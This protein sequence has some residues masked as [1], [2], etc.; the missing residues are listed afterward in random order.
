MW[1]EVGKVDD[2][3]DA[4]VALTDLDLPA[5]LLTIRDRQWSLSEV[6]WVRQD[7]ARTR[8]SKTVKKG[9]GPPFPSSTGRQSP[10]LARPGGLHLL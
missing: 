10:P 2:A 1:T 3:R 5:V 9:H 6:G 7:M 4:K 8:Q